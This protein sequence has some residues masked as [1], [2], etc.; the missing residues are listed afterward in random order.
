MD[1]LNTKIKNILT[2]KN[3]KILPANIKKDINILGITGTYEGIDTSDANAVANDIVTGKTAYVNGQKLTG[4]YTGIVPTGT[5]SITQNGT[6]DVTNYASANVNVPT[7]SPTLQSKSVTITENGTQT[8]TADSGYDGLDEVEVTTNVSGSGGDITHEEYLEDVELA[9]SI[10]ED[11]IPYIELEYVK[12]TGTQYFNTGYYP[13]QNTKIIM[14]METMGMASGQTQ[15]NAFGTTDDTT[16][17]ASRFG[18]WTYFSGTSYFRYGVQSASRDSKINVSGDFI[19][20]KF[21]VSLDNSKAIIETQSQTLEYDV[22]TTDDFTLR[23]S[24]VLGGSK[25]DNG[26]T[27]GNYGANYKLYSC[28]I[29]E[30]DV[31]I[32][33]W[34]PVINKLNNVVCLYDKINE[35]FLYNSGTG[36]MIAGGVE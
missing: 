5:K 23:Y 32:H 21:T 7:P 18:W 15:F 3:T 34:I 4:T 26:A 16:G 2:E 12:S 30:N 8:I 19:N 28:K 36:S 1:I 9:R 6:V 22:P 24:L 33:D 13:N 14:E 31:L 10:L 17:S 27:L 20:T 11:F 25:W 29:Y 35:S